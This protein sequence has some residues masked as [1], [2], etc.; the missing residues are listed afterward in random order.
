VTTGKSDIAPTA[1]LLLAA[2]L[3]RSLWQGALVVDFALYLHA[4]KWSAVTISAVLA[5]ALLL[6][7]VLSM[8][9][10]PLS[11]RLGRR[12]FLLAYD[13][14]QGIAAL[15][16]FATPATVPL[17]IAAIAGGFGRG[18]NGSAGPFAPIEQAWLAQCVPAPERGSVFSLN[19]ALGFLGMAIGSV[20]AGIPGWTAASTTPSPEA[21]MPLFLG[22]AALS[23]VSFLLI[24]L[25]KDAEQQ[26][27]DTVAPENSARLVAHDLREDEAEREREN[28]LLRRLVLA[29]ALNGA[30]I[31]LTGPLLSY[32]FA[33]RFHHGPGTIG[34][35]LSVAFLL[36]A[37]ASL[38]A[39]LPARRLGLVK[40]IVA[41]RT[42]GLLLLIAL[43]FATTFWLASALYIGRAVLNRGTSGPRS[44]VNVGIVRPRRRGFSS[45]AANAALQLPR[46]I[47][48]VA[49][50]LFYDAGF[51]REPFL[52][53]ALFQAGYI[54]IY[55][56]AFRNITLR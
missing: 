15:V 41:M 23:A 17:T 50:G 52:I 43:P 27:E 36:A 25:G 53:A 35:M 28:H 44:A 46:S 30:G 49:A 56:R 4:L 1:W 34:P 31:G 55:N 48:P 16:A 5:A 21:Y 12:R 14:I 47:G 38:M 42:I 18:G 33:L 7:A 11:D 8:L 24:F 45:A 54:W 37:A 9:L 13:A 19:A 6:G 29:N 20:L 26:R 22:A 2:R 32:W 51:F 10:G 39:R 3:V 40:T